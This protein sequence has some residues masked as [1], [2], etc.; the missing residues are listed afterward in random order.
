MRRSGKDLGRTPFRAVRWATAN[1][2]ESVFVLKKA[3]G[4]SQGSLTRPAGFLNFGAKKPGG[5]AVGNLARKG[6]L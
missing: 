2:M 3:H 6:W 5:G 4:R 1:C